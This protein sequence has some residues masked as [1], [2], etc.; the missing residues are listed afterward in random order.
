MRGLKQRT[1]SL[2]EFVATCSICGAAL[3]PVH[4]LHGRSGSRCSFCGSSLMSPDPDG[5]PRPPSSLDEGSPLGLLTDFE[6]PRRVRSGLLLAI[7][8]L[9]LVGIATAAIL[10]DRSRGDELAAPPGQPAASSPAP[11][12]TDPT[13]HRPVTYSEVRV[14]VDVTS[15]TWILAKEDG[16]VV[17]QATFEPG[18]ELRLTGDEEVTLRFWDGGGITLHAG[19]REVQTGQVGGTVELRL[20]LDAGRIHVERTSVT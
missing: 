10:R 3:R 9:V 15:P 16:E 14:R 8:I 17:Q 6:R 7:A 12:N 4:V 18:D 13:G 2:D 20:W 1:T 11:A 5:A 19:G